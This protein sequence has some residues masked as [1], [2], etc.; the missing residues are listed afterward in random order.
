MPNIL[1]WLGMEICCVKQNGIS[2]KKKMNRKV[3]YCNSSLQFSPVCLLHH[4]FALLHILLHKKKKVLQ[5][6]GGWN[7]IQRQWVPTA[8]AQFGWETAKRVNCTRLLLSN[9]SAHFFFGGGAITSIHFLLFSILQHPQ[10]PSLVQKLK[11]HTWLTI[12]I[13]KLPRRVQLRWLSKIKGHLVGKEANRI[14]NWL[15]SESCC[16]FHS[17]EEER[18]SGEM[19]KSTEVCIV[20]RRGQRPETALQATKWNKDKYKGV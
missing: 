13:Q 7:S 5:G 18:H 8:G 17:S 3:L 10:I 1:E 9:C 2:W 15:S 4:I 12:N 6:V 20:S 11:S 16:C 19:V 14:P